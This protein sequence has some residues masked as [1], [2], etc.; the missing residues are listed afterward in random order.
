MS[1]GGF[2][3]GRTNLPELTVDPNGSQQMEIP[4]ALRDQSQYGGVT[5][6]SPSKGYPYHRNGMDICHWTVR[7]YSGWGSDLPY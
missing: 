6:E 1:W 5:S 7:K 2:P 4:T 3:V